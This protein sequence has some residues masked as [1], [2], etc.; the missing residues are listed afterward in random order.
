MRHF[1]IEWEVIMTNT[2]N[3]FG[4]TKLQPIKLTPAAIAHTQK[5]LAK[6]GKGI[7]LRLGIK[8]TGCSGFGY[9]VA[10]ADDVTEQDH[11]FPQASEC[12]VVVDKNSYVYL[13][14][15]TVD[16]VRKGL[17]ANFVFLNPNAKVT[18]GC[19]ES[20]GTKEA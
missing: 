11:V 4:T 2:V 10:I 17:N 16:Y 7:G 14:G 1:H 6:H 8:K 3:T 19:G 5:I 9:E 13:Q 18:C 12:V 15:M 20:F